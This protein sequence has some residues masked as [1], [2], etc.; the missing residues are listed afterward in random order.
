MEEIY[1][2]SRVYE[3]EFIYIERRITLEIHARF[4]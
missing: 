3:E 4:I 2:E 1:A